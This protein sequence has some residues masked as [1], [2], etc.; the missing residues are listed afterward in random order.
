MEL[1]PMENCNQ[2]TLSGFEERVKTK[3]ENIK[4]YPEVHMIK[5]YHMY[6]FIDFPI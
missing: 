1:G 4:H 3:R 6:N 2:F 5:V